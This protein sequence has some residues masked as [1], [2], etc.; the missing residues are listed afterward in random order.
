MDSVSVVGCRTCFH[1][2]VLILFRAN[3]A[4]REALK[5]KIN[6]NIISKEHIISDPVI[7][8]VDEAP[9]LFSFT[10]VIP[11]ISITLWARMSHLPLFS[12]LVPPAWTCRETTTLVMP[13]DLSGSMLSGRHPFSAP[14]VCQQLSLYLY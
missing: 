1:S 14:S 13:L 12:L 9:R 8:V 5:G 4:K 7:P 3:N 11:N 2:A 6:L 10:A